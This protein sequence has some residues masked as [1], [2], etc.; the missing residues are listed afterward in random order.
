M[1][2]S[3]QTKPQTLYD[4]LERTYIRPNDPYRTRIEELMALFLGQNGVDLQADAE[5][6]RETSGG[7]GLEEAARQTGFVLGFE[8]CRDLILKGGAK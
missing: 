4:Q 8:Y 2:L 5:H 7:F 1:K 3:T 6:I